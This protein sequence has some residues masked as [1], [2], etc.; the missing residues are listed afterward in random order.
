MILLLLFRRL[1][2]ETKRVKNNMEMIETDE[3]TDDDDPFA[4]YGPRAR[5]AAIFAKK[6]DNDTKPPNLNDCTSP[7]PLRRLFRGA[8]T[9]T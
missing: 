6:D 2:A 4:T 9:K 5:A 1:R 8:S 7:S 3:C